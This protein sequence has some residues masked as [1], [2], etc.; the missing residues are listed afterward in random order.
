MMLAAGI[1]TNAQ[2]L[3]NFINE[4]N[5]F[6]KTEVKN[7]MVDYQGIKR[8]PGVLKSLIQQIAI[9]D[10]E[11]LSPKEKKAFFIN[12][13]NILV[14]NGIV[15]NYPTASPLKIN[16]FFDGKK[17][18]VGGHSMTLNTLEKEY[19]LKDTGD[20]RLHF[21]LVCAALSCPTLG[22]FA[23]RPEQL[24]TQIKERTQLALSDP[25][26]IRVNAA[27]KTVELSEIFKWYNGDF[28]GKSDNLISYINQFRKNDIPTDYKIAYYTYDWTLNEQK[29]G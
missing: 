4:A 11:S 18:Q 1:S 22:S 3:D 13:Y 25:Q 10:T 20:E 6:F 23:Y 8:Q 7:G 28:K 19:L 21:V 26:F 5:Q 24:E 29:G 12:T 16:G 27:D 15:E 17:H 14:I 2:S 9:L